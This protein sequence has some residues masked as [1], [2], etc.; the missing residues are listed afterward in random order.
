MAEK[1]FE[2]PN[3]DIEK[4]CEDLEYSVILGNDNP[5]ILEAK[6]EYCK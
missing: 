1:E 2:I 3:E 4:I 5:Q 6:K